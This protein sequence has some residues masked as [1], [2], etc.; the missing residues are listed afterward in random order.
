[1]NENKLK[2]KAFTKNV[3]NGLSNLEDERDSY[4]PLKEKL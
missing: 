2:E 3:E 4:N 1:M